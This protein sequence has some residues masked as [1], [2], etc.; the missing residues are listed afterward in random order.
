MNIA[1]G[2]FCNRKGFSQELTDIITGM[3]HQC[4]V[5][6]TFAQ[7]M[8]FLKTNR[9]LDLLLIDDQTFPVPLYDLHT[10][11]RKHNRSFGVKF[12]SE[13]AQDRNPG[14]A[15]SRQIQPACIRDRNYYR[16]INIS[17]T[18]CTPIDK[19][20]LHHYHLRPGH[21]LLLKYFENHRGRHIQ[22]DSMERYLWPQSTG[23]TQTLYTYIH[24]LRKLLPAVNP[25][26]T[27]E[28]L[29]CG[30]YCYHDAAV[31]SHQ[32]NTNISY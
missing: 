10:H 12:L 21:V 5:V 30:T 19:E 8:D 15:I 1:V 32:G 4:T 20:L 13:I 24:Q 16:I 17:V 6:P 11:I 31:S 7:L 27:I 9:N 26:M 29:S 14:D 25:E 3:G 18:G 28:R 23:H 2:I 22:L